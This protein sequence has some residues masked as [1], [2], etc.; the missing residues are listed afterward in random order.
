MPTVTGADI[1]GSGKAPLVDGHGNTVKGVDID[2]GFS[3][4]DIGKG[5]TI[6]HGIAVNGPGVV[7]DGNNGSVTVGQAKFFEHI[8][9]Y[10]GPEATK[11]DIQYVDSPNHGVV[12]PAGW[13]YS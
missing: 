10:I 6:D 12:F 7:G 3:N 2:Q 9:A 1:I 5:M 13:S 8:P 4:A 11:A